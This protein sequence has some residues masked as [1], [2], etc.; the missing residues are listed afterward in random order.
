ME[1]VKECN[2]LIV[3]QN[4]AVSLQ[5]IV[6]LGLLFFCSN[7]E[8]YLE[9]KILFECVSMFCVFLPGVYPDLGDALVV[10]WVQLQLSIPLTILIK[11]HVAAE[12]PWVGHRRF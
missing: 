1:R 3:S 12:H 7:A 4:K 9:T 6:S 8:N 5:W 11:G 10:T 2:D